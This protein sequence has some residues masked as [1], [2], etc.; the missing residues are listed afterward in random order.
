[1]Q[2]R[3]YDSD[4]VFMDVLCLGLCRVTESR[5]VA[6]KT[7][8]APWCH[9]FAHLMPVWG[10]RSNIAPILHFLFLRTSARETS[11]DRAH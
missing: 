4:Q 10:T 6:L 1:M 3:K 11:C 9:M 8:Y 5:F 2:V 7:N